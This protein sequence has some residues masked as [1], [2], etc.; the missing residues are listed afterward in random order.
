MIIIILYSIYP[1]PDYIYRLVYSDIKY[2]HISVFIFFKNG[3]NIFRKSLH[4][5]VFFL[6]KILT[7]ITFVP[8]LHTQI[9]ISENTLINTLLNPF[10]V[11]GKNMYIYL[12]T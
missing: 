6:C 9:L 10:V 3:K 7:K 5:R 12:F 1:S 11:Y 4:I 8:N 2:N